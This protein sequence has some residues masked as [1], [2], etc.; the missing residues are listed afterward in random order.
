ME[1]DKTQLP[2]VGVQKKALPISQP[3]NISVVGVQKN[4][5]LQ[6]KEFRAPLSNRQGNEEKL[7]K[8]SKLNIKKEQKRLVR[9]FFHQ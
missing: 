5:N 4:V 9:T 3:S 2:A 1:T 6:E 8:E 7:T